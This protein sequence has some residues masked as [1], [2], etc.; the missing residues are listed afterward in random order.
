MVVVQQSA[1]PFSNV[2][3]SNFLRLHPAEEPI[4][5]PLVATLVVIVL[6]E[7]LDRS[8]KRSL[9]HEDHRTRVVQLTDRSG[10]GSI[11]CSFRVLAIVLQATRWSKCFSA[12]W[13]RA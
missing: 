7:L 5:D 3:T 9:A 13:I 12:P 6:N 2:N 11:P 4:A 1:E 10:E 8:V